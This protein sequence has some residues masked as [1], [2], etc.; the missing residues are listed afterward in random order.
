MRH[1]LRLTKHTCI[2]HLSFIYPPFIHTRR[3]I[4]PVPGPNRPLFYETALKISTS[5]GGPFRRTY[6]VFFFD[7]PSLSRIPRSTR[8]LR[9]LKAVVAEMP[10][11]D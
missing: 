2:L 8:A 4:L 1:H 10:V 6:R 5:H 7:G 3:G 11:S 9:S